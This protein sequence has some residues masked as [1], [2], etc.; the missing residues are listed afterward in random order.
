VPNVAAATAAGTVAVTAAA[1][2]GTAAAGGC[3]LGA[4]ADVE[5]PVDVVCGDKHGTFLI[6][7][8]GVVCH[9]VSCVEQHAKTGECHSVIVA[10]LSSWCF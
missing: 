2:A 10:V 3:E 9:C 8:G 5:V 6:K 4:L 7:A 1:A